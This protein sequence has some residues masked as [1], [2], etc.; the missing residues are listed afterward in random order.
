MII[1]RCLSKF[2]PPLICILCLRSLPSQGIIS[3]NPEGWNLVKPKYPRFNSIL[4]WSLM[5]H[6][7]RNLVKSLRK[8]SCPPGVEVSVNTTVQNLLW[9]RRP[10]KSAFNSQLSVL[11]LKYA[12]HRDCLPLHPQRLWKQTHKA[13]YMRS[14]FYFYISPTPFNSP[15]FSPK[16][17][18]P[19][20]N[21]RN[22]L[23][24][25][26]KSAQPAV[27]QPSSKAS[28]KERNHER[29]KSCV[30]CITILFYRTNV[31]NR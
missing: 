21:A 2:D 27:E 8:R 25:T 13:E 31:G 1:H 22:A 6:L 29:P 24:G 12:T 4:A 10:L 11:W 28:T 17:P 19:D 20:K 16:A 14:A 5:W 15:H 3:G 23:G 30:T 7:D 18:V 26:S 9:M